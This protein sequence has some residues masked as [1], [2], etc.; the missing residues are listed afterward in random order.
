M[1]IPI[2]PALIFTKNKN[3]F[4]NFSQADAGYFFNWS[5]IQKIEEWASVYGT[6]LLSHHSSGYGIG[7]QRVVQPET[8]YDLEGFL[9]HCPSIFRSWRA[10]QD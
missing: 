3:L 5:F 7:V 4:Q 2:T 6:G 10:I 8:L 9:N 1:Y